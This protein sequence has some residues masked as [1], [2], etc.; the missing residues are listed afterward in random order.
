MKWQ[1][2]GRIFNIDGYSDDI[3]S[4]C[5][6][7]SA[8]NI[9]D[10]IFRIYFNTRDKNGKSKPYFIE[11]NITK[12]KEI[13]YFHEKPVIELGDI[14]CFDENGIVLTSFLKRKNE[15]YFY[16][17]GFP[18]SANMIFQSFT[19]L[20]ISI[21]K[22]VTA[23]KLFKGPIIGLSKEEPFWSAGPRIY[24]FDKELFLYYT[25]SDGWRKNK[26]GFD[27]HIYNIK[28]MKSKN[29][30]DWKKVNTSINYK[31]EFEYAIGIPS[32]IKDGI[33]NFKMW[34]SFRAQKNIKTYRI[35]YAESNDGLCW[36]RK[37]EEMEGF[38]VSKDGWDSEMICYPYVFDHKGCRYML[39]NGNH[40]GRTGFG[41]AILEKD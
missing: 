10:D 31:N 14:G 30:I 16:Y 21:D 36:I 23:K 40:Y 24:K 29:G 1:K 41:L 20:A 9:R 6:T 8:L 27:E 34:Y 17:S 13:L 11:I 12:P 26:N 3:F 28:L 37:D 35:G 4:H 2:L 19:G 33:N 39:Y 38:D 5:M 7:S 32:V 15:I 18:R 22:G 25:S